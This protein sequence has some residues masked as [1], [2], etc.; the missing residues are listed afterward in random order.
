MTTTILD[1]LTLETE[2]VL[3]ERRVTTEFVIRQVQEN[4]RDRRVHAEIELGPFTTE[5]YPGGREETR[6]SGQRGITVWE[7]EAY[8]AVRDTWTNA[9]LMV[10]LTEILNG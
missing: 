2:I 8:D 7:N 6:G 3:S 10:R 5:T 1:T 9:D 4:I